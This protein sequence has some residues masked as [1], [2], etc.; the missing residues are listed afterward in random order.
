MR[1]R[2][3]SWSIRRTHFILQEYLNYIGWNLCCYLVLSRTHWGMINITGNKL[4]PDFRLPTLCRWGLQSS[5]K[6][7]GVRYVTDVSGP[8]RLHLQVP[9]TP[10]AILLGQIDPWE[11]NRYVVPKRRART[12]DLRRATSQKSRDLK[13]LQVVPKLRTGWIMITYLYVPTAVCRFLLILSE[14]LKDW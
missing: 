12:T 4:H 7:R 5:E 13:R 14:N 8:Y 1:R 3:H 2:S 6:F 10:K 11:W 9:S